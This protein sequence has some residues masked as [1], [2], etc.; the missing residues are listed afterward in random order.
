MRNINSISELHLH[1]LHIR[2]SNS[3]ISNL[4][5]K[6]LKV[7]FTAVDRD[8]SRTYSDGLMRAYG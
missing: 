2:I 1:D 7:H 4:L 6:S 8:N 3:H 5:P